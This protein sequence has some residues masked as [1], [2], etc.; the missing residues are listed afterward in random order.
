MDHKFL[1]EVGAK[2]LKR[3]ESATGH[4]CQFA[5]IEAACYGENPDV[6]GVRHGTIGT[7]EYSGIT[8]EH[9]WDV[10]TIV[11]EAKTSRSDFLADRKKPHRI[12]P[13]SGMGRWRY[14]ICPTDLI[15]PEDLPEKWGLIY[16][17]SRGHCK[18]VVGAMAVPKIKDNEGWNG[19]AR[20]WRNGN[21]LK[22]SFKKHSF[23]ERNFQ[24]EMNLI[25]MALARMGEPEEVLYKLRKFH[26]QE[27]EIQELNDQLRQIR[28]R[29]RKY[30][31]GESEEEDS[32]LGYIKVLEDLN[33]N[34]DN[35]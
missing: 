30:E 12:D 6:I 26:K 13:A 9:G 20:Y 31:K 32:T 7:A 11:L 18:I 22:A 27:K 5:I 3:P 34:V 25:T 8:Y 29:L 10:G 2:F 16:V 33:R 1:C 21:D 14:Y 15:K 24:N 23:D 4:G 28:R 17:N 19:A 35:A